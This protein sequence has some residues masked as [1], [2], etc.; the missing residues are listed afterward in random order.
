MEL[1]R[2]LSWGEAVV[3]PQ[4]APR[5]FDITVKVLAALPTLAAD[6]ALIRLS[7]A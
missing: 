2:A 6:E 7:R 4:V 3:T 5:L 1:L